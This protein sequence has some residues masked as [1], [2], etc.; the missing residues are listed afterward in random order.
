[1]HH[2]D[3]RT[4]PNA[5]W[6]VLPLCAGHHQDN[7]TAIAVHPHKARFEHQ[8]GNQMDLLRWC[9]GSLLMLNVPVPAGAME[10]AG[11]SAEVSA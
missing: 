5:H 2:I 1:V 8:Y 7:G 3:G 10:A 6:L 4:K 9:V 11:V